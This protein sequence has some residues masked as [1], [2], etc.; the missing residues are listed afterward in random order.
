MGFDFKKLL[1]ASKDGTGNLAGELVY[2]GASTKEAYLANTHQLVGGGAPVVS[3][4]SLAGQRRRFLGAEPD[5][6]TPSGDN[7]EIEK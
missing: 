3:E 5:E 2:D 4:S 7:F 6:P 1:D